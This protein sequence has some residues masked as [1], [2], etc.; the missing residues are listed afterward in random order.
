MKQDYSTDLGD[1]ASAHTRFMPE[2]IPATRDVG[3][4]VGSMV[5]R[6][7][8]TLSVVHPQRRF[9][10]VLITAPHWVISSRVDYASRAFSRV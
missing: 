3:S 5:L 7:I 2:A 8:L 6:E 4:P 1:N 9:S 10:P